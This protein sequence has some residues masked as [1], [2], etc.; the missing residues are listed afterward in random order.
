MLLIRRGLNYR[1]FVRAVRREA[2]PVDDPALLAGLRRASRRAGVRHEVELLCLPGLPTP[3]LLGVQHPCI[4]LP[5]RETGR[6][7]LFCTLLHE[8]IHYRRRDFLCR[9]LAG[10]AACLHWWNPLA[11]RLEREM[12]HACELACDEA[13]LRLLRPGDRRLYGEVLLRAAAGH[14]LPGSAPEPG[15][16]SCSG[17]VCR[18]SSPTRS[19]ALPGPLCWSPVWWRHWLWDW[20]RAAC[21]FR[22]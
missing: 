12:D 4:V 3:M 1:S 15:R 13:V 22:N 8:L 20:A 10:A 5:D 9:W 7:E 19:G 2:R 11:R 17:T 18:R 21:P 14:G 6:E 16:A